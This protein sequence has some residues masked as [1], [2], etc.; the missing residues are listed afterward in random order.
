MVFGSYIPPFG[1]D[2][3]AQKARFIPPTSH[4]PNREIVA[5]RWDVFVAQD[6]TSNMTASDIESEITG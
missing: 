5:K 3:T 6:E 2:I 4:L 1:Q